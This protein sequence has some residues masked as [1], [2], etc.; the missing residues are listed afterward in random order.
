LDYVTLS[1]AAVNRAGNIQY[2]LV[3][4]QWSAADPR[5]LAVAAPGSVSLVLAA[6][7]RRITLSSNGQSTRDMGID[8]PIHPPAARA[9]APT[10]C[11]TDLATLQFIAAA[12]QLGVQPISDSTPTVYELWDDERAALDAFV[13]FMGGER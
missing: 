4:Y 13:R 10:V 3:A 11:N 7:E 2:V 8:R 1:A 6:D 5:M 12:R 9:A